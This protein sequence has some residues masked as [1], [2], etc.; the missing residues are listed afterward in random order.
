VA[1][2][3]SNT[4]YY[5]TVTDAN[6]CTNIDSIKVSIRPDPVFTVNAPVN[7]CEKNIAQLSAT[8]GNTYSWQP[9]T[10]LNN[11][12]IA[13]PVAT[14]QTSTSYSVLITDTVCNNSAVLSTT[15][16]V[17]PLPV[18]KAR[19][20]NDLDCNYDFSQLSA[21]GALQYEWK[22][23]A[24][25]NK[26]NIANPVAAPTEPTYYVVKGTDANGCISYD[27]VMVNI[28]T[29]NKSNYLMPS[30]FTP[31]DDGLN[32]CYGIKYWGIIQELD[33]SIYNRWGE[34]IFHT[35]NP[36]DCWDGTYKG[37][38]QNPDV[39]VYLIKAKTFCGKV[40]KKGTFVL[41]R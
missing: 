10:S 14:P 36:S 6:T 34:K 20:S 17:L 1:T 41:I 33:F 21:T 5:I 29:L 11:P 28:T 39:Y 15:V 26:F 40:F 27:S 38:K 7:V 4:T 37:V 24:S 23:V 2:P 32:D 3:A 31:N 25:L 35:S 19:S 12:N 13:N 30:A 16:T 9:A 22:P 8:G 18:V